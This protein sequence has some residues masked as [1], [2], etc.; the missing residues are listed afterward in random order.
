MSRCSRRSFL[1]AAAAA[2]LNVPMRRSVFAS[3][4]EQE[5]SVSGEANDDL[6]PFDRLMTKFVGQHRVPGAA[7]AVTRQGKLVYARGFGFADVEQKEPVEP[8][9]LFRIASVSKPI[10]AVAVMR[11]VEQG[12]LRLDD[13]VVDRMQ[14]APHV[15]RGAEPDKRWR[16]ITIRHCLQHTGGW[17][18]EKSG[19]PIGRPRE[20][21]QALGVPSPA[22]PVDIVRFMMGRPLDFDP[23]SRHVYSNLGYLV[24][25]RI[26]EKT[27]G[28]NYESFVK[29]ELLTPLGIEAAQLG[30]PRLEDR[31]AS[32]V[33]YYD[34]QKRTGES[35]YPPHDRV[36]IQY[37]VDNLA[38]YEEHGGWIASAVELVRFAS[39]FDDPQTSPLLR[40]ATIAEMFARPEGAAG[41][42]ADGKPKDAYYGCGWNVRPIRNTGKA[43]HW[44][45][46][47]IAGSEALLVRR[48]DGL[49]WAVVFNTAQTPDGKQRL[50]GLID[51]PIH[52][53]A[54]EVKR[55]PEVDQFTK[56]LT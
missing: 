42:E 12:R 14:L 17:D 35:L 45:A 27:T 36:P 41:Y 15:D 52:Q 37:G 33:K 24:L 30:R 6:A 29:K 1:A 51:G 46:G 11:L 54:D 34:S 49:N 44:H 2:G 22:R 39:A 7:L 18:R 10:T 48:W 28:E 38:G 56:L 53:A 21:A 31:A 23:G 5:L 25:G 40:P 19:D 50:V 20:I 43:N 9:A 16:Q 55:W 3:S 8:A 32:E 13:K 4:A 26:I 47:F